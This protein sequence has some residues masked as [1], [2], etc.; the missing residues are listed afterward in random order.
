MM[1]EKSPFSDDGYIIRI[2]KSS[3]WPLMRS[4]LEELRE[5]ITRVLDTP[6][7]NYR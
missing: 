2:G 7:E 6:E 1:I 4:E 3:S 5:E